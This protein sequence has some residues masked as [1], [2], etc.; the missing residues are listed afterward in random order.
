MLPP[1]LPIV[2]TVLWG[3]LLLVELTFSIFACLYTLDMQEM[4][5]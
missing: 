4:D 1:C 2:F 3:F 5:F